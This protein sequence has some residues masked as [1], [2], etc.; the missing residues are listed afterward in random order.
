MVNFFCILLQLGTSTNIKKVP[1]QRHVNPAAAE[2]Q[3][4]PPTSSSHY[5]IPLLQRVGEPE[6]VAGS[7]RGTATTASHPSAPKHSSSTS[8]SNSVIIPP[9]SSDSQSLLVSMLGSLKQFK[10][11]RPLQYN[12]KYLCLGLIIFFSVFRCS[13]SWIP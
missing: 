5:T 4:Q 2:Q 13:P 10:N 7:N 6:L 12:S 3:T 11:L 9:V 8:P 1:R